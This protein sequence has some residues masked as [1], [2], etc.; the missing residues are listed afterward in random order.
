MTANDSKSTP[1]KAEDATLL[2]RLDAR[3][4]ELQEYR[5]IYTQA[6]QQTELVYQDQGLLEDQ[7]DDQ[8][9]EY[10]ALLSEVRDEITAQ[11]KALTTQEK[12][13]QLAVALLRQHVPDEQ[14]IHDAAALL[15]AQS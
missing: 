7:L 14:I 3:I 1:K 6:V 11:A 12:T 13:T 9:R 8:A 5:G 15:G 10:I 4:R 2:E